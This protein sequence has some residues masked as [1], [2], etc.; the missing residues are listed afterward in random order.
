MLLGSLASYDGSVCVCVW[1]LLHGT[2]LI[3]NSTLNTSL[4]STQPEI[5]WDYITSKRHTQT[6]TH[7]DIVSPRASLQVRKQVKCSSQDDFLCGISPFDVAG[8]GLPA[9]LSPRAGGS[10][11]WAN[12]I[13]STPLFKMPPAIHMAGR[14]R[15]AGKGLFSRWCCSRAESWAGKGTERGWCRRKGGQRRNK[16][17]SRRRN[18]R[19][20]GPQLVMMQRVCWHFTARFMLLRPRAATDPT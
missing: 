17:N 14:V 5:C 12:V 6:H 10:S 13:L 19:M 7:L 15:A 1:Q 9:A 3:F 8:R 2:T 20:P 4:N 18:W 11:C 16:E